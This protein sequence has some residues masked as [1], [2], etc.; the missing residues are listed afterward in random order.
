MLFFT[1]AKTVFI[2]VVVL[3]VLT[4]LAAWAERKQSALMQDRI[5]VDR[6]AVAGVSLHGLL[7]PMA[8]LLKLSSR[9]IDE[10]V[11]HEPVNRITQELSELADDLSIVESFSHVVSF[12][13]AE[14]M[15]LFDTSGRQT[16]AAVLEA[17][18]AWSDDPFHTLLYTHGHVDHVGGAGCFVAHETE[19]G[20]PAP[21]VVG[22][23]NVSRRF[24]RYRTT[25]GYNLIINARQFGGLKGMFEG[26]T[27][28][29]AI[30]FLPRETPAPDLTFQDRLCLDIGGLAIELNHAKGETDDHMWAWLPSRKTIC[31]GDFFIWNFPNAGNPQKVQ[32]YP[33]EWAA[34][35]RSMVAMNAELFI[36]A[37]GLPIEGADRIRGVLSDVAT[38]LD[39]VITQTLEMMNSGEPLDRI[40]HEVEVDAE[41]LTKP[42]LRPL[43]D[44]PEFVVRNIWRLYGGW[45]DGN[46][47][48]LKP[49]PDAAVA[50]ELAALAGGVRPLVQ[51]ATELADADEHRLACH[52]I[53][54]AVQAAPDDEDAHAARA[55]IYRRRRKR[56]SSLM[57]K[58]IFA[59][60]AHTS[61]AVTAAVTK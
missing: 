19:R 56:E 49:A 3:G 28:G 10:G 6:A 37:H 35:I 50:R 59:D 4:P 31:A 46:P 7:Q 55:A 21:R 53:E 45:Y 26:R 24:D 30:Q 52:L 20:R 12:R 9:I 40:I 17:L 32:R 58:G 38:V 54:M 34:A 42:Y 57:A 51:R 33:V 36:P 11:A 44:E 1:F 5:G 60:A 43:Y 18:R 41:F 27:I 2:L 8:D 25:N 16:G 13:T 39:S 61:E 15:V 22:H 48:H 14:G 29:G 47:A 23:E